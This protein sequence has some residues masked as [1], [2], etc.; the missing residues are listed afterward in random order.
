MVKQGSNEHRHA[1]RLCGS[2]ARGF[3]WSGCSLDNRNSDPDDGPAQFLG[4][5]VRASARELERPTKP[6]NS[7]LAHG[8]DAAGCLH[9]DAEAREARQ[10]V[11]W[12]RLAAA[13]LDHVQRDLVA[14]QVVLGAVGR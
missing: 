7:R 11:A 6:P 1:S 2:I 5:Q 12:W 8:R 14:V 13:A 4:A 10:V 3:H 9:T